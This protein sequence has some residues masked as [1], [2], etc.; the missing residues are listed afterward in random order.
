M[1]VSEVVLDE[2]V[3]LKNRATGE[4]YGKITVASF[5]QYPTHIAV[6]LGIDAPQSVKISRLKGNKDLE[7]KDGNGTEQ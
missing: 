1:L 2:G 6:R 4:E 3:V 5:I 7:S